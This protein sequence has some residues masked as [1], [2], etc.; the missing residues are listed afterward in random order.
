MTFKFERLEVWQSSI[1]FADEIFSVADQLP[2]EYRS[3]LGDQ[4]RRAVLSIPTNIAEG[5][6]RDS[7][8]EQAYF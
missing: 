2:R 6:G 8:K 7:S 4:S 1:A 3:S 5:A